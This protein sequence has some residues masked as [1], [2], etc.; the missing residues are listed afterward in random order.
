MKWHPRGIA[1]GAVDSDDDD[2]DEEEEDH[3]MLLAAGIRA[4]VGEKWAPIPLGVGLIALGAV[5]LVVAKKVQPA[6]AP[7]GYAPI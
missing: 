4:T 6:A 2:E 3:E 1:A 5:L 7:K